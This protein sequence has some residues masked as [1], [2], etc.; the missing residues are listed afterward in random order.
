MLYPLNYI[1]NED[2]R[3]RILTLLNQGEGRHAVAQVFCYGNAVR[4][5]ALS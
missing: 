3:R 5:E 4:S 2:Y 1:D